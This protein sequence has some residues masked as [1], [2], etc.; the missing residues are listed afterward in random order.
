MGYYAE[1]TPEPPQSVRFVVG[2]IKDGKPDRALDEVVMAQ[3]FGESRASLTCEARAEG[4]AA[5]LADG[6][7]PELVRRFRMSILALR[8]D[9]RLVDKLYERKDRVHARLLPGYDPEGLTRGCSG[10]TGAISGC[11]RASTK[12][13]AGPATA[14][15]SMLSPPRAGA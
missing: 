12:C 4:I 7:P 1:R 14:G 11:H 15:S 9:P 3:A 8:S 6:Q 10:C 13:S 2:V 5:D